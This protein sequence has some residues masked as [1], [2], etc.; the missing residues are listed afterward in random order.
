ME[1]M[2]GEREGGDEKNS[3]FSCR[4]LSVRLGENPL[5]INPLIGDGLIAL[6][7]PESRARTFRRNVGKN[8]RTSLSTKK[9][10]QPAERECR[11]RYRTTF[12]VGRRRTV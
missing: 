4:T 11:L 6:N 12:S 7:Y 3:G 5:T 9:R 1:E 2:K 8:K 10:L